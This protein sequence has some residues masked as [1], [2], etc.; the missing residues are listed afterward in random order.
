ML[1][2]LEHIDLFLS[3]AYQFLAE[4]VGLVSKP[5]KRHLLDDD[6]CQIGGVARKVDQADEAFADQLQIDWT[7]DLVRLVEPMAHVLSI[8]GP[9]VGV[10]VCLEVLILTFL[11]IA[12]L[13]PVL[14]AIRVNLIPE[15]PSDL[16]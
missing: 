16:I 12:D 5:E 14:R 6:L 15:I 7:F 9:V 3:H 1:D 8:D 2:L 11:V 13:A 10:L 4:V